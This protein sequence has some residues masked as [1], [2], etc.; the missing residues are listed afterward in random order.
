MK[1]IKI[2]Y[3]KFESVSGVVEYKHDNLQDF[4]DMSSGD[5][6][7]LPGSLQLTLKADKKHFVAH[8][9]YCPLNYEERDRLVDIGVLAQVDEPT[10]WVNKMAVSIKKD[11]RLRICIDPRSL[12]LASKRGHYHFSVLEDILPDLA[13]A[14]VFSTVDLSHVYWHCILQEDCSL[15]TILP[16]PLGRYGWTC[17][18]FGLSVSSETFQN[19]FLQGVEG[20]VGVACTADDT[21][22][23]GVGDTPDEAT[24]DHDKNLTSLLKHCKKNSIR[25]NKEKVVLRAQQLDLM[26][27]Q[28]TT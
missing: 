11:G 23:H 8:Q 5:L 16:T 9:K 24:R 27:H 2:N 14:Q 25:L 19:R 10:V 28:L 4:P 26:G 18:L 22:I 12:N 1:L 21:L 7:T 6:G 20:P 17:L 3:V 13:R 15:L